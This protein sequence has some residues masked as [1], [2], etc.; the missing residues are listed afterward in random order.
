MIK[1]QYQYMCAMCLIELKIAYVWY[2]FRLFYWQQTTHNVRR[3]S[4]EKL[5]VS[6]RKLELSHTNRNIWRVIL[7]SFLA[8]FLFTPF[9]LVIKMKLVHWLTSYRA[10]KIIGSVI[11]TYKLNSP[12]FSLSTSIIT[13]VSIFLIVRTVHA[14]P[15]LIK[16]Y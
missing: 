12:Y 3:H 4:D 16:V 14:A 7:I 1:N 15:S 8:A 5:K 13:F 6:L 2:I 9:F 10:N 11:A